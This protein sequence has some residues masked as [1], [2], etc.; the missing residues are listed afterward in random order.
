MGVRWLFSEAR[1][2]L[3]PLLPS[4][5][6]LDG[7]QQRNLAYEAYKR[8]LAQV[9]ISWLDEYKEMK[10]KVIGLLEMVLPK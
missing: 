8:S 3:L 9:T 7:E 4:P 2:Q 1:K 6:G 10:S 5:L